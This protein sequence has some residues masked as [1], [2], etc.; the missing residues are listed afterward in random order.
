MGPYFHTDLHNIRVLKLRL[1]TQARGHVTC[2]RKCTNFG[3]KIWRKVILEDLGTDGRIISKWILREWGW[4]VTGCMWPAHILVVGCCERSNDPSGSIIYGEFLDR[5]TTTFSSMTSCWL[6]GW[7]VVCLFASVLAGVLLCFIIQLVNLLVW[8]SKFKNDC[9]TKLHFCRS[10][11]IEYQNVC[12]VVSVMV[13][14]WRKFYWHGSPKCGLYASRRFR[15]V[16]TVYLHAQM[17]NNCVFCGTD[18]NTWYYY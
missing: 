8:R 11:N 3:G 14:G 4:K 15:P 7:L 16:C 13:N 18:W 2:G 6:V 9:G 10:E 1:I 12:L 5:V 17:V